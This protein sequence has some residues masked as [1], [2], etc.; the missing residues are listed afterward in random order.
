[1]LSPKDNDT[2]G[3]KCQNDHLSA[4]EIDQKHITNEEVVTHKK[5]QNHR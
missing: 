4:L 3:E 1:M 5:P 2:T